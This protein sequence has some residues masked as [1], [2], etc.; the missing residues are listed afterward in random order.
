M[1]QILKEWSTWDTFHGRES[2]LDTINDILL[3]LQTGAWHNCP[4][5]GYTQQLMETDAEIH[6]QT[7]G[8]T[9]GILWKSKAKHWGMLNGQEQQKKM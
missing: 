4:L 6:N 5:W 2:S 7:V 1:E 9:L 8:E 3:C